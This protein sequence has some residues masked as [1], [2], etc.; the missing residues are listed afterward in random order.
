M[1]PLQISPEIAAKLP[2]LQLGLLQAAVTLGPTGPAL[3]AEITAGLE[4]LAGSLEVENIS[5]RPAIA[6]T[7]R[8]YKALGKDPARYRASAEALSRRVVQGKGLYRINNC[9]DLLNLVSVTTGYSIGGYNAA[10]IE[11]TAVLGIG[12][13]EEP[14][15]AIG[16]GELNIE[17]LPL[18]RD[19]QGAFG[20]PTSDSERTSV[21]PDTESFFWVFY[22]F[23]G[24]AG[25][26]A[27]MDM[28]VDLMTRHAN[29]RDFE[30]LVLGV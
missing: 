12:R 19:A 26:D 13:A 11:G 25:L 28:A 20:T 21:G 29:G 2:H 7:R 10:R 24:S 15:Q 22:N 8:A 4:K 27:A 3:E 6:A 1:I 18:L 30:R 17:F 5:Q 23:D 16:R 9:V 14:Y